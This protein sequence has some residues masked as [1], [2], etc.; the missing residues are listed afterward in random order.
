[1][2]QRRGRLYASLFALTVHVL[3]HPENTRR[4]GVY[5]E[6]FGNCDRMFEA[7]CQAGLLLQKRSFFF[8]TATAVFGLKPDL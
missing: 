5:T 6:A 7:G 3:G 4:L 2:R 8:G 1:M